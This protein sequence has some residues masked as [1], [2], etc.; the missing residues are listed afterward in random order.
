MW[1]ELWGAGVECGVEVQAW[2]A[3]TGCWCRVLVQG[4]GAGAGTSMGVWV[5]EQACW[6]ALCHQLAAPQ[7]LLGTFLSSLAPVV[8]AL[9][10][11]CQARAGGGL[12]L[13]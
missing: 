12:E 8:S 4:T 2:G 7:S 3:A 13:L 9:P 1:G 10:W 5:L 6:A 11:G